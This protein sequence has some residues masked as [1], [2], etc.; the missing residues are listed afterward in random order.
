[1]TQ[2]SSKNFDFKNLYSHILHFND[3]KTKKFDFENLKAYF[4][5]NLVTP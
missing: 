4:R 1:M 3:I 5:I 2:F